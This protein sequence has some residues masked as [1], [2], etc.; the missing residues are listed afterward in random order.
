MKLLKKK[1][2]NYQKAL[3]ENE[4][5]KS[6]FFFADEPKPTKITAWYTAEIPINHGPEK[7]W[8]LSGLI[9]EINDGRTTFLCSKII[10]N[11]KE[12]IL[13]SVPNKEKSMTQK[14]YVKF[15]KETYD[16][17]NEQME[18]EFNSNKK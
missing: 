10:L 14:D 18:I 16:K 4:I 6:N 15:E 9:L 2:D 12:K 13:I 1:K 7:Y 11:P 3:K 17:Q 8:G 5:K